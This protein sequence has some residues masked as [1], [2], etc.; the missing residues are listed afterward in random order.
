MGSK[1]T[2]KNLGK[3]LSFRSQHQKDHEEIEKK[4]KSGIL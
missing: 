3:F 2:T 1:K 4:L